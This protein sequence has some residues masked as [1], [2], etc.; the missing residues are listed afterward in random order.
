[1]RSS[2]WSVD[3]HEFRDKTPFGVKT[4]TNVIATLNPDA[5]RR[6]VIA[7]HYDSKIDPPGFLAATDSAVPCAMMMNLAK[8]MKQELRRQKSNN[9]ELTLQFLFLDGEEA[10]KRWTSTDSIYGARALAAD[11]EKKSYSSGGVR[12]NHLDRIDMFVLLDLL[13]ARDMSLV[14]LEST[15]GDWFDNLVRIEQSL[16]QRRIISGPPIFN[17]GEIILK[18]ISLHA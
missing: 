10:F 18:N 2:G 8:T 12:G 6:M 1:M 3:L 17:V 5:P 13:G 7:C 15:T 14:K 4:F 11:W 16:N 9:Q